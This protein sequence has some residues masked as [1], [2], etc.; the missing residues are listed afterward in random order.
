ME[1]SPVPQ[2]PPLP[3][4]QPDDPA[5]A[6]YCL[7]IGDL[8]DTQR[9]RLGTACAIDTH[10]LLTSASLVSA[11]EQLADRFP[12]LVA[13]SA[14]G[15][16]TLQVRSQKVHP[17]FAK[18]AAEVITLKQRLAV[19]QDG[20][21]STNGAG[22]G[23]TGVVDGTKVAAEFAQLHERG[24]ELAKTMLIYDIAVL[25]VSEALPFTLAIESS[26]RPSEGQPLTLL[27]LPADNESLFLDRKSPLTLGRE[28]AHVS[29]PA[30]GG[31]DDTRLYAQCPAEQ[32]RLNWSGSPIV[33]NKNQVVA[34]Y[35][36]PS[37][38]DDPLAPPLRERLEAAWADAARGL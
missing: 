26:T 9:Y 21:S 12:K 23:G 34:V 19:L 28:V 4:L 14:D 13:V 25:E 6:M 35:C 7:T 30:V 15:T 17:E 37:P 8:R 22:Q 18:A 1:I 20:D 33:N 2:L 29:V 36:R 11:A 24:L 38:A 10:R 5:N 16:V 27:G 3:P 32:A 31:K